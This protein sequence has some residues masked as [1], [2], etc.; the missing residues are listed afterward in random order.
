LS[1]ELA[2]LR[3]D[4]YLELNSKIIEIKEMLAGLMKNFNNTN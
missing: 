2:F 1:F 4:D 3:E